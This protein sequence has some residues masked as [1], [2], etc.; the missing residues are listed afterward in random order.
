[1]VPIEWFMIA[2]WL[3][4][5]FVGVSRHFPRELGATIG[6]VGMLLG[7]SLSG[8]YVFQFAG[9]LAGLFGSSPQVVTLAIYTLIIVSSVIALYS[10]E[11]FTFIGQWPPSPLLG[12]VIDI[13]IALFNGWLVVGTWWFYMHSLGYPQQAWG[14]FQPPISD[15]AKQLVALTPLAVVPETQSTWVFGMAL[16]GL[17]ALKV[18]R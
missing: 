1:M 16:V 18:K 5:A 10:G 15:L 7:F 11:T 2:L 4:F 12:T 6:F 13:T 3:V 8:G 14:M 17:I 9:Q